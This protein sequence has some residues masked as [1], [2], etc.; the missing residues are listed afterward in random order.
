MS[1]FQALAIEIFIALLHYSRCK[2]TQVSIKKVAVVGGGAAGFFA[3]LSA[4]KHAPESHVTIF[5]KSNKLLAKVKV[6]GGG[7]CNVTHACFQNGILTKFYPRG[8]KQLRKAFEQFSTQDTVNWFENRGVA[9]KTEA[10]NRMFPIS[11]DSQTIIDCLITES[12]GLGVKISLGSPVLK[13]EKQKSVF[14]LSFKSNTDFF[15]KVIVATG[16]SPKEEGFNWLKALGHTIIPPVPSLFTFNMPEESI[17]TLM[18]L[19]VPDA[20]VRVQGTKLVQSGPLLIT[21]WGMSGPAILKTSAWG[22]RVLNDM[23]YEFIIH[24]NWL[25]QLKEA[26]LRSKLEETMDSFGKRMLRNHNPFEI[27]QRLWEYLLDKVSL[28]LEKLWSEL[29]KKGVNKLLNLLLN[30]QYAVSGKTTFKEEFVTCGGISLSEVDFKTMESR[31]CPGLYFAGEVLD[32]DGVTGG[33]NFQA[34]WTTGYIAGKAS[35]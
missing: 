28:P 2:F 32:V 8:D 1:L 17:K 3:A 24:I 25:G 21:H 26:A 34:A 9:L 29:G 16:G 20:S 6:S 30:D 18:G 23:N 5:E 13:I 22:A 4:K 7:R 35:E 19:S 10:D 31:V 27:P 33:F 14:R 12:K 11:D 15:D